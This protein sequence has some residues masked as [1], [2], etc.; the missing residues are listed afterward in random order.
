[1][2]Q[3]SVILSCAVGSS[4]IRNPVEGFVEMS[5]KNP[6]TG[7]SKYKDARIAA[8]DDNYLACSS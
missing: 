5:L 7:V 4:S 1:M 3:Y 6:S 8:Q 2:K